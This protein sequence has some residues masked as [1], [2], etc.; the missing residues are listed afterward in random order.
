M[1]REIKFRAWCKNR[2]MIILW[3]QINEDWTR[4]GEYLDR[5]LNDSESYIPMQY[6]GRKDKNDREIYE[7]DVIEVHSWR[8]GVEPKRNV[9]EWINSGL[10]MRRT[11]PSVSGYAE[12]SNQRV[13][14]IGNIYENPELL[15]H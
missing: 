6:T 7:G 11:D 14:V 5:V 1:N 9:V 8:R 4:P 13:E 10:F 3:E 2:H 15:K 12:L